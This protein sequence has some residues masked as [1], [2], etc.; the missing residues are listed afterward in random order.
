MPEFRHI[1]AH[2]A[3]PYIYLGRTHMGK[4]TVKLTPRERAKLH[5]PADR[6]E[7]PV[8]EYWAR[9][10]VLPQVRR[11]NLEHLDTDQ[12]IVQISNVFEDLPITP[13]VFDSQTIE[14][15][16]SKIEK[17]LVER[18]AWIEGERWIDVSGNPKMA[19]PS[20]VCLTADRIYWKETK[21]AVGIS[22]A[23]GL[24]TLAA[25]LYPLVDYL[26]FENNNI[27]YSFLGSVAAI[28]GTVTYTAL[29]ILSLLPI[30][31][32][33]EELKRSIFES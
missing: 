25:T 19:E 5:V 10:I 15:S 16:G 11:M 22:T 27:V 12:R 9:Q 4:E 2:K 30:G 26:Y 17:A 1:S 33:L 24:L 23:L 31:R 6:P 7:I 8:K 29:K 32:E 13:N 3:F 18:V 14:G 20:F 21:R 28:I